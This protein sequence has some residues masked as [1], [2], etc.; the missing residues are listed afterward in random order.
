MK[1]YIRG[2][3]RSSESAKL[4]PDPLTPFLS[5][6]IFCGAFHLLT[7]GCNIYFNSCFYKNQNP[8]TYRFRLVQTKREKRRK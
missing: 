7:C 5:F 2:N 3:L 8:L 4:I 1:I 6:L